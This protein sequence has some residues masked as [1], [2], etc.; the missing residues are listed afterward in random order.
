MKAKPNIIFRRDSR[1]DPAVIRARADDVLRCLRND[2]LNRGGPLSAVEWFTAA[3]QASGGHVPETG[4]R[5]VI[6]AG[7]TGAAVAVAFST[8]V[9]Q[10]FVDSY[11]QTP[12]SLADICTPQEVENFLPGTVISEW[13]TGRLTPSGKNP[14]GSFFF[15]L[16]GQNW[17]I[18]RYSTQFGISDMDLMSSPQIDLAG[19]ATR[20]VALRG[21]TM[22][23][24]SP[25]WSLL[26]S[27]P[28]MSDGNA[29]FMPNM[30]TTAAAVQHSYRLGRSA[31]RTRQ[32]HLRHRLASLD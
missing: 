29:V 17:A 32:R 1:D 21:E 12:N 7:L 26:L 2:E 25:F 22:R 14:A 30:R 13:Q 4:P 15:G 6:R 27:N 8:Q 9:N 18:A 31:R 28:I 16:Q 19:V 24:R 20:S 5:D 10:L 11:R 23:Y 3:L